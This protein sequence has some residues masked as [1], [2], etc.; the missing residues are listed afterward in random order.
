MEGK[1]LF[2]WTE[3]D[4]PINEPYQ[5]WLR[6]LF[7]GLKVKEPRVMKLGIIENRKYQTMLVCTPNN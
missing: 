6:C 7:F 5:K 1:F 4:P 2:I 3:I